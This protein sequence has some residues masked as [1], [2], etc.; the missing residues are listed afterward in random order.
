MANH[1]I[2]DYLSSVGVTPDYDETLDVTPQ[3]VLQ[4]EGTKNQA[5][6]SGDDDSDVIIPFN[7]TSIFYVR[8]K[9]NTLLES[10]AGTIFDFYHDTAKANGI[11]RSFKFTDHGGSDTHEY[12]VR[13]A[14]DVVRSIK[15]AELFGFAEIKLKILGRAPVYEDESGDIYVDEL[16]EDFEG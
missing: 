15:L 1:E 16:G 6:Y 3:E 2:Y 4:E 7:N 11:A 10:D 5:V 12:T 14:S 8:L 13:F 9:W